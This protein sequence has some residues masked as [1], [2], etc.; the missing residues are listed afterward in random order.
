MD[1]ARLYAR[2]SLG[3]E[4]YFYRATSPLLKFPSPFI[5]FPLDKDI[6]IH[7]LKRDQVDGKIRPSSPSVWN[8]LMHLLGHYRSLHLFIQVG[9]CVI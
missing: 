7:T 6:S 1:A 4:S 3:S 9:H 2:L 5:E 8:A